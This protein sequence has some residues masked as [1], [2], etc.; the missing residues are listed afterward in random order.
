MRQVFEQQGLFARLVK[1]RA[2]L[3][4]RIDRLVDPDQFAGGIEIVDPCPHVF[5]RALDVMVEVL[6]IHKTVSS[7]MREAEDGNG[8]G[9]RAAVLC[10]PLF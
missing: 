5:R 4:E 10:Q 6:H 3:R 7:G 2:H 9:E 1:Q 8:Q